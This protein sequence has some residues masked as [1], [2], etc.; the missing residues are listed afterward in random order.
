MRSGNRTYGLDDA[1][2]EH[3]FKSNETKIVDS[4]NIG[5]FDNASIL[6]VSVR[7][8]SILTKYPMEDGC[9]VADN[10]INNQT[11]IKVNCICSGQDFD[12]VYKRI[13]SARLNSLSFSVQTKVDFYTNMYIVENSYTESN[14]YQGAVSIEVSFIEQQ[15]TKIK[16]N[17][18]SNNDVADNKNSDTIFKQCKIK[19]SSKYSNGKFRESYENY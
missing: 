4:K 14:K 16:T 5:V 17:K 18:L 3:Q 12:Q 19:D 13:D 10:K 9:I 6:S 2:R 15:F 11:E 7:P 8:N 1:E